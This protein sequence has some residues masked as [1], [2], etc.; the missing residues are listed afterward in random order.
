MVAGRIRFFLEQWKELTS[1][2]TILSAVTGYKIE[3]FVTPVQLRQ[4]HPITMAPSESQ[5]VD[6]QIEKFLNKGIIVVSCHEEGEFISN[7]FLRSK[8][9]GSFRMIL[10]LKELNNFVSYHHF[11]MES[12]NTCTQL[13]RPG[14]FMASIDLK[15]AYYLIAIA[16]EHQKYLK[17]KWKGQLY[18]FTCLAQGL[19]SAPRLFTKLMKPV[20]SKLRAMGH[21]SSGYI[22]DSFLVGYSYAECETN[23]N[24]TLKCFQELG[25]LPH[26]EKSVTKPT[27][28]LQHLGFILNSTDMTVSISREKHNK[29]CTFA[30]GVLQHH[31]PSIREVAKLI[32]MMVACLPGVEYGPLFYRQLDR[33]KTAA[34]KANYGNFDSPMTLSPLGRAD[35]TW[36]ITHAYESKKHLSHG[37]YNHV[38]Y[39]DASTKG[40]G[41]HFHEQSTGGEWLPSER[42]HHIN[43]LELK[44][45]LFGLQSFCRDLSHSHVKVMTDNTTAL[46]YI[47]N[48]GGS[49]SLLCNTIAREI[50]EWCMI[51]HIWL[52]ASHIPGKLNVM[53]DTASRVF[54]DSK[55]WKLDAELFFEITSH[56]GPPEM[57]MFA[58]RLNYQMKPYVSWHPDPE[59]WAIDAFTVD[60]SNMFFYAFPPFSIL[61]QVLQKLEM[62]QAQAILIVPN[63]PTQPWY[64]ALTR[65]LIR[66]PILL[67]RNRSNV[68]LPFNPEKEH[69]LADKLNLMACRLSGN[70]SQIREFHHK[71]RQQYSIPGVQAHKNSTKCSSING[72]YMLI[73][74][75]QIPFIQL[76]H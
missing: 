21:I 49:Q 52:T 40:W 67:P 3:F 38:V 13:M 63:W 29:L 57:D 64:P 15:D 51:R 56:L 16:Q 35:I 22:D 36:W 73:D 8:R 72:N 68:T 4:P 69:P 39:T 10:N 48:M 26:T 32:G 42:D 74:K 43:Y 28:V 37:K 20:Y 18:Q 34:L 1:D 14:C 66:Q 24:D 55:E 7:V 44:A 33:D 27:Q 54:D 5:N 31:A 9:D 11:K 2:S 76:Y 59:A 46:A 6:I 45:V 75:M 19:S 60:W 62:T 65:L 58:S 41:A 71:L 53:A 47:N 50:W 61:P 12:I 30:R 70:P 25:F 23:V 17:F